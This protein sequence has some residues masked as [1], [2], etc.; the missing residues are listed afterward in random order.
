MGK[1]SNVLRR[2][3]KAGFGVPSKAPHTGSFPLYPVN[4]AQY[5]LTIIASPVYDTK[6]RLRAQVAKRAIEAHPDLDSYWNQL[7]ED[8]IKPRMRRGTKKAANP[9]R[10]SMPRNPRKGK[11]LSYRI[12]EIDSAKEL[13][14]LTG[15][16]VFDSE[17]EEN[18]YFTD[19]EGQIWFFKADG[20]ARE[21]AKIRSRLQNPHR[22]PRSNSMPRKKNPLGRRP[23]AG[24]KAT[25]V[26]VE[27][28]KSGRTHLLNP[29]TGRALCDD[30][31]QYGALVRSKSR[32]VTCYRC[33][34][35]MA[36]NRD[37]GI[38][39]KLPVSGKGKR[40]ATRSQVGRRE[41]LHLQV[42]GGREGLSIS[43]FDPDSSGTVSRVAQVEGIEYY[44][45]GTREHPT[46]SRLLGREQKK[47]R[48]Q[49]L[50]AEI[51]GKRTRKSRAA[52][53]LERGVGTPTRKKGARR[54]VGNPSAKQKKALKNAKLAME[55]YHSGQAD[56]LAEAWDM[57]RN[58]PKRRRRRRR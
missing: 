23:R 52:A 33:L 3:G 46:Q 39:R 50:Q 18:L 55:L 35:L 48:R 8:T 58:N 28:S 54:V 30:A 27:G 42:P 6:R 49:E 36:L 14:R 41:F 21:A 24:R 25:I 4:R 10:G 31:G 19:G 12:L 56:S 44:L 47:Y 37:E 13:D 1:Y 45:G 20:R 2:Y 26:R 9:R 16:L 38:S 11:R 32:E 15:P 34:K 53:F 22:N 5:A 51:Q 40:G 43:G 29:S 7:Q 57:V 17:G